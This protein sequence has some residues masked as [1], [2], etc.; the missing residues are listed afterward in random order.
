MAVLFRSQLQIE[1]KNGEKLSLSYIVK[2]LLATV[3]NKN[4]VDGYSAFPKEIKMYSELIPSFEQLYADVGISVNFGPRCYFSG[5]DPTDI[6][7]MEDLSNYEMLHRSIGLDQAHVEKALAWLGKFHAASM[8]FKER[9]G[10]FGDKFKEG[11]YSKSMES[12]YQPY[13]DGYFDHYLKALKSLPNGEKL[14][15]KVEKW[16]GKL[17]SLVCEAL[18]YDENAFNVLCH[19]KLTN[20]TLSVAYRYF[21]SGDMWSNNLMFLYDDDRNL[22]DLKLVD[23]QLPFWGSVA[24]DIYN[25]MMSSW[26]IDLK[27]KKFDELIK[28]YFDSLVENL[29][30]LEYKKPL[31][32]FEDLKKE[33]L[34]RNFVGK[35][36]WS[37]KTGSGTDMD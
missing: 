10:D 28:Y 7:I 17:Y 4:M 22:K 3:Y 18:D 35:K 33:L 37:L 32:T 15:E 14:I 26:Q 13:Y 11:V 20:F 24:K 12:S 6:I 27:V 34:K 31:P 19:G 16:R 5:N 9:N 8:V 23:F 1:K 25:F 2:C 21:L 36:G 29:T 30:I